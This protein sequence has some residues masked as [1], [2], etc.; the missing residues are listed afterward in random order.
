MPVPLLLCVSKKF[1]RRQFGMER[2]HADKGRAREG[3]GA[4]PHDR[5]ARGFTSK[6]RD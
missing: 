4:D 3:V 2:H 6:D 1:E 5:N